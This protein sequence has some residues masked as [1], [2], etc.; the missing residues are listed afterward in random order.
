MKKKHALLKRQP[1]RLVI[2][3]YRFQDVDV[4]P[5]LIHMVTHL[6]KICRNKIISV[7]GLDNQYVKKSLNFQLIL[8]SMLHPLFLH[9]NASTKNLSWQQNSGSWKLFFIEDSQNLLF[10]ICQIPN[11]LTAYEKVH[12]DLIQFFLKIKL[13]THSQLSNKFVNKFCSPSFCAFNRLNCFE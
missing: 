3:N 6:N 1:L 7:K 9:A 11:S 2:G 5:T 12:L 10:P 13:K 4:V 8:V